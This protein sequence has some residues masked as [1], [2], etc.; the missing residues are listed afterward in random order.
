MV[1]S[2]T[3]FIAGTPVL[4]P[5]ESAGEQVLATVG[6]KER[7]SSA[8]DDVFLAV[9]LAMAGLVGVREEAK[10]ARRARR[11]KERK[12]GR[13]ELWGGSGENEDAIDDDLDEDLT[14]NGPT[15]FLHWRTGGHES[16]AETED[17]MIADVAQSVAGGLQPSGG[18]GLALR[19]ESVSRANCCR[20]LVFAQE[21]AVREEAARPESWRQP[22]PQKTRAAGNS[23]SGQSSGRALVGVRGWWWIA[24]CLLLAALFAG[25]AVWSGSKSSLPIT[26]A[27]PAS[28]SAARQPAHSAIE[29][30]RVGQR[31]I[32][33][34]PE[35]ADAGLVAD[36]D[37]DPATWRLLRLH[38][39]DRWE[40][41][42][43]DTI[44]VETL[45][46]PQWIESQHAVPGAMV[47]LPVDLVEMGMPASLRA[48]V[49]A[50]EPC[51]PIAKGPGRVVLTTINHLNRYVFRLG[52]T[53]SSGRTE[54][55]GVTGFHKFYSEDRKTWVSV[56]DL[57]RGERVPGAGGLLTVSMIAR[58][59]GVE[60]VY[61]MTVDREHVYH[62]STLGALVHNNCQMRQALNAAAGEEGAHIV[63]LGSFTGRACAAAVKQAK[64]IMADAGISLDSNWNGFLTTA[65]NHLGTHTDDFLNALPKRLTPYGTTTEDIIKG[66]DSIMNMLLG[67]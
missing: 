59:R 8:G 44:E 22:N 13:L 58:S 2:P 25:K 23:R 15:E 49:V 18:A 19:E 43:L 3:C 36:S 51:P 67:T 30:V 38:A 66:L 55:I 41:G 7:N 1:N 37:V 17:E 33:G 6:P 40:D 57:R 11:R 10:S 34:N 20:D 60:R 61:N 29:Q 45:Q 65:R 39:E 56:E 64:K 21:T 27:T 14:D 5:D 9:G 35:M 24:A 16:V 12:D 26:K 63:P 54:T 50:I 46:E 32:A 53:D 28:V 31:V 52:L 42:T 4:V 48:R 47:P 62:V